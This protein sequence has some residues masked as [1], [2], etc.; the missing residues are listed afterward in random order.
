MVGLRAL[1][2]PINENGSNRPQ[3]IEKQCTW[4]RIA[5]MEYGSMETLKEG[6]K[7]VLDKRLHQA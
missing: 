4:T 6:A 1:D 7:L 3:G 2:G 5:C